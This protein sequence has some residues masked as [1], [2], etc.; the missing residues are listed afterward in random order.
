MEKRKFELARTE[1]AA[2]FAGED[3]QI[4]ADKDRIQ[5]VLANLLENSLRYC[6][7][8]AKITVSARKEEAGNT[9]LFEDN[10]PGVSAEDLAR[11]CEHFY[12]VEKSRSKSRGG[13]GLGLAIVKNIVELHGGA[14]EIE[15]GEGG[16]LRFMISLPH[17]E[18]KKRNSS[19]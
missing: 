14:V 9:I 2:G 19:P 16:G 17:A 3:I 8:K 6:P 5:Q 13:Y 15:N 10:G 18:A 1:I 4:Y 12:R 11:L 7:A